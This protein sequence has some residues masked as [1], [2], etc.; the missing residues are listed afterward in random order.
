M[1]AYPKR[2]TDVIA[3]LNAGVRSFINL[4]QHSEEEKIS[5]NSYLE[6][7][8]KELSD[9]PSYNSKPDSILFTH[10]PIYDGQTGKDEDVL[11]LVDT[12][13]K[14]LT[15]GVTIYIH[16]KGGHGRTGTI[17]SLFLAKHFSLDAYSALELIQQMHDHRID[18]KAQPGRFLCPETH[19]Q[20]S[21]VYKLISQLNKE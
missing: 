19:E 11:S 7:A 6:I 16:C 13:I 18:V 8:Q 3:L 1:G 5:N 14:Q 10:F 20:K 15:S 21:Q 2:K 17:I 4:V 12:I 9:N